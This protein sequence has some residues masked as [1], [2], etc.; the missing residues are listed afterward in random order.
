MCLIASTDGMVTFYQ[1]FSHGGANAIRLKP[2]SNITM[3]PNNTN[4][5][6]TTG[7]ATRGGHLDTHQP[8]SWVPSGSYHP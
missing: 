3:H 8:H 5:H 2:G 1:G 4:P 6:K 7:R